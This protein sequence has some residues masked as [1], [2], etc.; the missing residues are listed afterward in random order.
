MTTS[1]I[2]KRCK[3]LAFSEG[4]E[5][6]SEAFNEEELSSDNVIFIG[7][8]PEEDSEVCFEW[9][10]EPKSIND[11][12]YI[13]LD[14]GAFKPLIVIELARHKHHIVLSLMKTL[15]TL[16]SYETLTVTV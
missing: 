14:G 11:L 13:D 15:M 5:H 1:Y 4:F 6:L 3:S 16:N 7:D 10:H 12:A 9:Q 8:E 2:V